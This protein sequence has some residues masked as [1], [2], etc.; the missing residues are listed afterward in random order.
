MS[1]SIWIGPRGNALWVP[2][3]SVSNID[4]SPS[5]Y[6][7][8]VNYLNGGAGVRSSW[9]SHREYVMQWTL[10]S[11][12]SLRPLQDM[13]AGMYGTGLIF[14]SNPMAMDRNV[15]PECW[16]W[17]AQAALDAPILVNGSTGVRPTSSATPAN[18]L[19]YPATSI[20]YPVS[21]TSQTLHVPIPP[22]Y[23][24]W[25]GWHGTSNGNGGLIVTP[26]YSASSVGP[27]TYP[28]ILPVTSTTRC[29]TS[30]SS[31]SMVGIDI[32]FGVGAVAGP[33]TSVIYSGIMVQILPIGATPT[34]GGF[35]SGQGDSG[36]VFATKP[37]NTPYNQPLDQVGAAAKLVEVGS[38][39]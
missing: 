31:A 19:G 37:K 10:K 5:G 24:A 23:V 17:P 30:Y 16:A 25:L 13:A 6:S 7:N 34:L 15:L 18:T 14:W 39:V 29:N 2:A 8:Q 38:W 11:R 36:C 22:G 21:G 4:F 28:A 12:D 20:S 27:A 32:S 35:I 1:A 26:V 9:A 3:P 33:A